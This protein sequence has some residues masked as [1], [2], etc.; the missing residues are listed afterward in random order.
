MATKTAR[1]QRNR[2]LRVCLEYK[3]SFV[4]ESWEVHGKGDLNRATLRARYGPG[5]G[6]ITMASPCV[7]YIAG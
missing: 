3:W 2:S 6:T 5:L 4:V 7:F 1:K